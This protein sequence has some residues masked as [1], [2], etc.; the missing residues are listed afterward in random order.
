M[1]FVKPELEHL[2]KEKHIETNKNQSK[3]KTPIAK[4]RKQKKAA[5]FYHTAEEITLFL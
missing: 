3:S 4:S 2:Y 1:G 5:A